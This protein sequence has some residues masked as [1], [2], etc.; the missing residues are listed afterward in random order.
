MKR[1]LFG[2]ASGALAIALSLGVL[3]APAVA[4]G[5][6]VAEANYVAM[7]GG[8]TYGSVQAAIDAARDGDTVMLGDLALRTEDVTVKDKG[9]TFEAAS[10][11]AVVDSITLDNADGTT[12]S[13]MDFGYY[14]SGGADDSY[15]DTARPYITIKD[16]S[17]VTV[18]RCTFSMQDTSFLDYV[19]GVD[20]VDKSAVLIEGDSDNVTIST[21][22]FHI[23]P[24]AGDVGIAEHVWSGIT[25]VGSDAQVNDLTVDTC[26]LVVWNPRFEYF[27]EHI[28]D[29]GASSLDFSMYNTR[30]LDVR[31]NSDVTG[32]Y[33]VDGVTVKLA[34][35][36][37]M[38]GVTDRLSNVYGLCFANADNVTII[39]NGPDY[40]GITGADGH[41]AGCIGVLLGSDRGTAQQPN[42]TI[43]I[44]NVVFDSYIGVKYLEGGGTLE[45]GGAAPTFSDYVVI[46]YDGITPPVVGGSSVDVEESAGGRVQVAPAKAA[47][48][49]IVTVTT[50]PDAGRTA[51]SVTAT[52]NAGNVIAATKTADNTWTFTMPAGPVTVAAEF[53]CDGGDA[54]ASSSLSDVLVGSWYH[55]AVDWAVA[56]GVMTGYDDGATFGPDD[57][58]TRA[59]LAAVLYKQAG[60][61]ETDAS[62]IG[63]YTDL[64]AD[65]WYVNAIS[66]ATSQGLM[67]GYDDGTGRFDPETALSREQL[68]VVLWRQAGS[69]AVSGNLN[70]FPDGAAT[71]SWATDA[72]IWAVDQGLLKGYDNTGMLDP[73]G[74]LTRAMVATVLYR[75]AA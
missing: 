24:Y 41:I 44:D 47:E 32:E 14:I 58:L 28:P 35:V 4:V 3:A 54:C 26:S 61:P 63:S 31:G 64:D 49:D 11:G 55:D 7:V 72:V 34:S 9:V 36:D 37:N 70:S 43:T 69:P 68:A 66:W 52:D 53:V 73:T 60:Q 18:N 42:G 12:I 23:F 39:G 16:S 1:G 5:D 46:P 10:F 65:G 33:G 75:Q 59:M 15:P 6:E 20:T 30:L 45:I 2:L 19:G 8:T 48:G 57:D 56:Q 29:D 21:S 22:T 38:N 71:S 74:H 40:P 62:V 25:V 50:T 67:S 51:W 17:D 13:N 27:E